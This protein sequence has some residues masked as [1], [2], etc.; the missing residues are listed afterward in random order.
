MS[1]VF[2]NP[3]NAGA[4]FKNLIH[5]KMTWLSPASACAHSSFLVRIILMDV[6]QQKNSNRTKSATIF[7]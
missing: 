7:Y 5:P 2:I 6:K 3:N 4:I 1:K